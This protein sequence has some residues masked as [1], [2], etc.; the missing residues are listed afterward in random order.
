M[1]EKT[2]TISPPLGK[3]KELD[4]P[5]L[6]DRKLALEER[7]ELD[8]LSLEERKLALEER[9]VA[10]AEKALMCKELVERLNGV[11]KLLGP[12]EV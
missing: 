2:S 3:R 12:V 7:K 5:S 11:I 6:E 4:A 10:V 9:K 8:T 1:I